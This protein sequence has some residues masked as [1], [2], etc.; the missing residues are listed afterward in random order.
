MRWGS[1]EQNVP[2]DRAEDAPGSR[3]SRLTAS[4]TCYGYCGGD[5]LGIA[6]G[7]GIALCCGTTPAARSDGL[8]VEEGETFGVIPG[9]VLGEVP[10]KPA[11]G[12]GEAAGDVAAGSAI[13]WRCKLL[14]LPLRCA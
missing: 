6:E 2:R 14:S 13:N 11:A 10:G 9:A 4:R 1:V 12:A 7:E 3:T 5:A 8:A